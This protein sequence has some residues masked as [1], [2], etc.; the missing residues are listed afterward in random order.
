MQQI[1]RKKDGDD[2]TIGCIEITKEKKQLNISM[3]D[4]CP[5]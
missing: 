3:L 1:K 4:K 5:L 2:K